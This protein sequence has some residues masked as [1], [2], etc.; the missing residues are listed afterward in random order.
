MIPDEPNLPANPVLQPFY[1]M[2]DIMQ[3]AI[4]ADWH[5]IGEQDIGDVDEAAQREGLSAPERGAVFRSLTGNNPKL[6]T[7]LGFNSD[8]ESLSPKLEKNARP[9]LTREAADRI[10]ATALRAGF[11]AQATRRIQHSRP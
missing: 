1:S 8:R 11:P 10:R 6:F 5:T 7:Y 2:L 3:T 9:D 4:E